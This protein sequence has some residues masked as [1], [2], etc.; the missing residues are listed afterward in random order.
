MVLHFLVRFFILSWLCV[1]VCCMRFY[2]FEN[3]KL[4]SNTK[5]KRVVLKSEPTEC[6]GECVQLDGC[7]SFYVFHNES[8]R[9]I[10]DL[11]SISDSMLQKNSFTMHF[12]LNK[13]ASTQL[14]TELTTEATTDSTTFPATT[15]TNTVNPAEESFYIVKR[16]ASYSGC[17]SSNLK[18][19]SKNAANSKCEQFHFIDG[20]ALRQSNQKC[21]QIS[22]SS[23]TFSNSPCD[24]FTFDNSIKQF[25]QNKIPGKCIR[26]LEKLKPALDNCHT[27][28][29]YEKEISKLVLGIKGL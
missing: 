5:L 21:A 8:G 4:V 26:F 28:Y 29:H 1:A 18:L 16:N 3:A 15:P 23:V 12:T 7:K 6:L 20:G 2:L 17:V 14:L 11:F 9:L 19:I 25:R 27:A 10:C 13:L 24:N 22:S